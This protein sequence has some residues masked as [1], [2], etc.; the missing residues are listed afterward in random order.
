MRTKGMFTRT[1]LQEK[2]N[3]KKNWLHIL[4]LSMKLSF[5]MFHVQ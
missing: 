2:K 4:I 5:I 1:A 3:K